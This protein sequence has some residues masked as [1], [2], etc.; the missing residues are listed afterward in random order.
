[1]AVPLKLAFA[2]SPLPA[3]SDRRRQM[4]VGVR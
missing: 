2:I 1:M 3:S 4:T